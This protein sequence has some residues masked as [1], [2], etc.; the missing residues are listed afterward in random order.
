VKG[1]SVRM[2]LENNRSAGMQMG[3]TGTGGMQLGN[4]GLNLESN[5]SMGVGGNRLGFMTGMG[6]RFDKRCMH[7]GNTKSS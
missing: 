4:T 6:T 7:S 1:G 3:N 2:Q 5:V